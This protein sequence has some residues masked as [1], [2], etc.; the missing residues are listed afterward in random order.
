M[1]RKSRC[2]VLHTLKYND[3]NIIAHLLSLS[4]GEVTMMVPVSRGRHPAVRH[5]LFQPLAVLEVE[6]EHRPKASFMKPKSAAPAMP[7]TSLPYDPYKSTMA[8]FLAEF[9]Y[10]AV[11]NEPDSSQIYDYV[12]R[13]IEWLDTAPSGFSNFHL[14][15]LLR[16]TG[17]LGFS[18]NLEEAGPGA[19]FDLRAATFVPAQPPHPDFIQP[20][21]AAAIPTLL[22]MRYAN[23]HLFRFS[24]ADRSRLLACINTY[25]R[26]H[27][28]GFP[29]LKS[30]EVL[31]ECFA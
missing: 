26:L 8:F 21:A 16:L 12:E 19:Y 9:L 10:Y 29:E 5:T 4:E 22:R 2:I 14:V 30:L 17:F 24:G 11:R 7:L 20:E 3:R 6:W 15:F 23:M 25:Y 18:P 31:K 28:P 13:S 1:L 27:L